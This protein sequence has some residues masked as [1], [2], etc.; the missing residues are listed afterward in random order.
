MRRRFADHK[1]QAMVE[2]AVVLPL[3]IWLLVGMVDI[4][5]MVSTYLL[6]ENAARE[7][8]RLGITGV[9]DTAIQQR[10]VDL[11]PSLDPSN[12]T[13]T[14]SPPGFRD[15]GTDL[16]VTVVY[17]YKVMA[18]MGVIGDQVALK[19]TLTARME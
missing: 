5:R 13:V 6:V 10:A 3:L 7:A 19:G 18:L 12:I 4:G 8:L 1:G 11:M 16:T 17:Q 2:M 14:V 9:T 15:S